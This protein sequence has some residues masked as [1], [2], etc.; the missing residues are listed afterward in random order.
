PGPKPQTKEAAVLMLADASE[1]ACRTLFDPTAARIESLV[2]KLARDRL[3]DGQFDECGL[4]LQEL[5]TIEQSIVK[6]LNAVYH[7]RIK[8]PTKVE[9]PQKQHA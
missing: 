1:S 2:A 4:T 8:Y 9:K 5:R 3:L 7:S 6:S